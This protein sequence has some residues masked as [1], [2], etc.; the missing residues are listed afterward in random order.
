MFARPPFAGI[1]RHMP[2]TVSRTPSDGVFLF[3]F[4]VAQLKPG[5]TLVF[6]QP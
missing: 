3:L 2:I 4:V 1:D 6:A 5:K